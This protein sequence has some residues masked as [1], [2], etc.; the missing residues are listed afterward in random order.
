MKGIEH[1]TIRQQFQR[2]DGERTYRIRS[3]EMY[4]YYTIPSIFP[5]DDNDDNSQGVGMLD[6]HGSAV[7]NHFANKL[8]STMFSPNRPFFRLSPAS[9]SKTATEIE[10]AQDNDADPDGQAQATALLN[11]F[12]TKATRMEK[13]AVAYLEKIS[14]RT[15]AVEMAK[16]IVITG[17]GVIK[18]PN[19]GRTPSVYNM[20]DY[21][22]L[23]DNEGQ[24][25]ILIVVDAKAF[26]AFSHDIQEKLRASTNKTTYLPTTNVSIYTKY[27]LQMDGRYAI[28][29]A[30]DEV[31]LLH[32]EEVLV[33][34]EDMPHT[35]LSWN[36]HRNEN[37]GRGLVEDFAGSFHMIDAVSRTMAQLTARIA[38]Q[39]ILVDPQS[40]ID[41]E[42][43][44]RADSA[45]YVSGRADGISTESLVNTQD[46][47]ALDQI[48]E[49]HKRQISAAF[50]YGSGTTRQAERVTA[51]EIRE[52]AAELEI[53]HGGVYSRFSSD[54]QQKAAN[55]SVK[56]VSGGPISKDIDTQIVT[57]M[58]SLS[59][60]G[61]MQA[62][63]VWV[64]D[65]SLLNAVPEDVRAILKPEKFA[66]YTAIQRGVDH[67]AFVMT[68]GEIK[69][70]REAEA[71]QQQQMMAQEQAGRQEEA[72]MK[73]AM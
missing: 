3:S 56:A 66:D 73:G 46:I 70:K 36:L 33:T 39:K 16:L 20:K 29:Q 38:S 18:N 72:M 26:G 44:N 37:Y 68:D 11:G 59:R 50:L 35:H 52:S 31:D 19:D 48:M 30:T 34:K 60:Q 40:G 4:A 17:D 1:E 15:A 23:K 45:S 51:E 10:D 64:E 13:K 6:S 69:Q 65:L 21:V 49:G 7:A 27:E 63:R 14:Y 2:M 43:L 57:G 24:D 55:E 42:E 61:E 53:A 8:V 47:L 25:M 41:V 58:N 12:R 54:W 5:R 22:C 71:Q 62:V 9:D 32:D 67:G 28:T